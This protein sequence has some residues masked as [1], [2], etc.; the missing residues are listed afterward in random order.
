MTDTASAPSRGHSTALVAAAFML[1]GC[2][3]RPAFSSLGP[4]LPEV[5]RDTG[6]GTLGASILST[7]P[8]L[9]LGIFGPLA[10]KIAR[11]LGIELTVLI[12]LLVLAVGTGLRGLPGATPL[13]VGSILGGVGIG[14]INVLVP[15]LIKRDFPKRVSL[16]L[17]VHAMMLCA[18]GALG[19]GA[20]V[21]LEREFNGSWAASL[22]F[23]GLPALAS[24][25]LWLP[26][27]PKRGAESRAA[28]V[29][30]RGLWRDPLAWQVTLFMALQ[31][32]VFYAGLAWFPPILR[33]R[34]LSPEDAGLV[35]STSIL[36]QLGSSFVAPPLAAWARDQRWAVIAF[37]VL[38][39]AGV[40]GCLF[41]PISWIWASSVVLGLGQGAV[42]ALALSMIV[43]RS[44]DSHVA[45]ELSS[46][47]QGVGYTVASGASLITGLIYGSAGG[48]VAVGLLFAAMVVAGTL[49]GWGAG[50][51]LFVNATI[52][53]K[54]G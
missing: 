27:V 33:A 52:D 38:L 43:L 32:A 25:L 18:G 45:A 24:F 23:W 19:A 11:R 49:F 44:R 47:V 36:V 2:N 4:V 7:A 40:L 14:I 3:L 54:G 50:R 21:P 16:M 46:M 12:F 34:G 9:C 20:A 41:A 26:L 28:R 31:S 22:A 53:H 30:V 8:V 17:G 51:N 1:L 35:I 42:F 39:A 15:G 13:F 5:I 29:H 37:Q 10:P 6:I 48:L